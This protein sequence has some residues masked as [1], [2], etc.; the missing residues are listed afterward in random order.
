MM[1]FTA[2]RHPNLSWIYGNVLLVTYFISCTEFQQNCW[3]QSIDFVFFSP[4]F[5]KT[6]NVQSICRRVSRRVYVRHKIFF[7]KNRFRN[8]VK[9][10]STIGYINNNKKKT[11]RMLWKVLYFY[12]IS[13]LV[14]LWKVSKVL[15]RFQRRIKSMAMVS[16]CCC[17]CCTCHIWYFELRLSAYIFVPTPSQL[18]TQQI[19]NNI[20]SFALKYVCVNGIVLLKKMFSIGV[21]RFERALVVTSFIYTFIYI[22]FSLVFFA[23]YRINTSPAHKNSQ[24]TI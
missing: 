11:M 18:T 5:D 15:D 9:T 10:F 17:H 7:A 14:I 21:R 4:S 2:Y 24:H 20:R 1:S 23:I 22:F 19:A 13:F 6:E 3:T 16:V 12:F 8:N